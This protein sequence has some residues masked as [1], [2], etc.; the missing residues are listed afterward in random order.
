M[1]AAE[2][3]GRQILSATRAARG[4]VGKHQAI[5]VQQ[6]AQIYAPHSDPAWGK[7][8]LPCV[9]VSE[10][11]TWRAGHC[12]ASHVLLE[13]NIGH[14]HQHFSLSWRLCWPLGG[15]WRLC[16]PSDAISGPFHRGCAFTPR[17]DC[18]GN[19]LPLDTSSAGPAE[20]CLHL[21]DTHSVL[22][23]ITE[24]K[25][26]KSVDPSFHHRQKEKTNLT[27]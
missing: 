15:E 14:N 1:R 19:L 3:R 23:R 4:I 26:K 25:K 8:C 5:C 27:L 16:R 11:C 9:C 6:P 20:V 13:S 24:V 7:W 2:R 10:H 17:C 22:L 21:V 12:S 18:P